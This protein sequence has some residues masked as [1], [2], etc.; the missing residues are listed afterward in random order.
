MTPDNGKHALIV[1]DEIVTGMGM[2]SVLSG[3]G[4]TSFAFASTSFQAADQA[5]ARR[6]DL[7]TVDVNLLH[8]TGV[9]AA[10]A[11]QEACGPTPTLFVTGDPDALAGDP[12]A[13]V[14]KKP[15]GRADIAKA[16]ERL[17]G[18]IAS[19]S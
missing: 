10:H 15:F 6:P 13:V 18:D 5:R 17:S 4:F 12:A 11:V 19:A 2:Q 7:V 14:V 3:L 8:G 9:D 16:W 1:E